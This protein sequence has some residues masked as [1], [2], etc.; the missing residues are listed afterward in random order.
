MAVTLVTGAPRY[1]GLSTDTKPTTCA[2]GAT[3]F[4]TD[5]GS[6]YTWNGSDWVRVFPNIDGTITGGLVVIDVVHHEVHRGDHF[7]ATYAE[8]LTSGSASVILLESPGSATA[9]I[10]ILANI[11]T[12]A[13]GTL[14]FSEAP[15]A[16][17]GTAVY[18]NNNN[19]T[20]AGSSEL[21]IT[22]NGAVTTAGTVLENGALGGV[23]PSFRLGGDTGLRNEWIF[24]HSSRYLLQ[25]T[26]SAATNVA[27]NLM[28]YE[29]PEA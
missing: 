12:S 11:S 9:T 19:L 24:N 8:T 7:T 23:G 25:F 29:E 22:H 5:R 16:T 28:W 10:H 15:N 1:I 21:S 26:S 13:G 3:Y 17:V 27:W 18:A 4:N 6:T 20:I 2:V 14:I